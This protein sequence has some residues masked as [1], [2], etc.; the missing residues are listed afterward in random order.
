MVAH[1]YLGHFKKLRIII[2]IVWESTVSFPR[3]KLN[4]L[5]SICQLVACTSLNLVKLSHYFTEFSKVPISRIPLTNK[6]IPYPVQHIPYLFNDLQGPTLPLNTKLWHSLSMLLHTTQ[7]SHHPRNSI[8]NTFEVL[9]Y[10]DSVGNTNKNSAYPTKL[11]ASRK[12]QNLS[13][14]DELQMLANRKRP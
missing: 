7:P 13:S 8:K 12:S 3:P 1:C 9:K 5:K 4:L 10:G 6:N 2:I 14:S 11:T